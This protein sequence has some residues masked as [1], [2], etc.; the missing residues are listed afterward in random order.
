M[1]EVE[2]MTDDMQQ[3]IQQSSN[4]NVLVKSMQR[5]ERNKAVKRSFTQVS[6]HVPAHR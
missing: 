2:C 6:N 3:S 5:I 1:I 4:G